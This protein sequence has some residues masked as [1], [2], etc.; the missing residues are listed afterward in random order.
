MMTRVYSSVLVV[1]AVAACSAPGGA[2]PELLEF[3]ES[4][5]IGLVSSAGGGQF[6]VYLPDTGHAR[7]RVRHYR[8]VSGT[9]E[10]VW[11]IA[12]FGDLAPSVRST[13]A[14]TEGE[15]LGQWEVDPYPYGLWV[16]EEDAAVIVWQGERPVPDGEWLALIEAS[17]Q[18]RWRRT[19]EDMFGTPGPKG[20]SFGVH[21]LGWLDR[22]EILESSGVIVV[23]GNGGQRCTIR[24]TDGDLEW[25]AGDRPL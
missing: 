4:Q 23:V 25:A 5:A 14:A 10:G 8:K 2:P 21:R 12:A 16:L 3:A 15:R 22:I 6:V 9:P 17:G 20:A 1:A 18:R 24:L 19:V 11:P 13:I 7:G